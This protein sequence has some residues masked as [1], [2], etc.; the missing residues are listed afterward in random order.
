LG[1]GKRAASPTP[2]APPGAGAA[3]YYHWRA[4]RDG[5]GQTLVPAEKTVLTGGLRL[6]LAVREAGA[7]HLGAEGGLAG[8]DLSGFVKNPEKE[9]DAPLPGLLKKIA[10]AASDDP[11][12][13]RIFM[14]NAMAAA[15]FLDGRVR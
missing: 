9:N 1:A 3:G 11:A 5:L 6:A 14:D 13:R 7:I 10:Q 4:A 15:E 2:G 8:A 12:E